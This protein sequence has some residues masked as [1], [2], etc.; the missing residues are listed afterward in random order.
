MVVVGGRRAPFV[1][2]NRTFAARQAWAGAGGNFAT[3]VPFSSLCWSRPCSIAHAIVHSSG[4]AVCGGLPGRVAE[5]PPDAGKRLCGHPRETTA[6]L[7]AY[8]N[9]LLGKLPGVRV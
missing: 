4:G 7:S 1:A 8:Q 9:S 2:A 3:S 6:Q 5:C